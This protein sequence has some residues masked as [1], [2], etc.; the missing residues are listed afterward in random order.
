MNMMRLNSSSVWLV[1]QQNRGFTYCK[2]E[3]AGNLAQH[4]H[5]PSSSRASFSSSLLGFACLL[6]RPA[7]AHEDPITARQSPAPPSFHQPKCV[8][9]ST[10][11]LYDHPVCLDDAAHAALRSLCFRP[12][13]SSLADIQPP[14]HPTATQPQPN[15]SRQQ[16]Q[17]PKPPSGPSSPRKAKSRAPQNYKSPSEKHAEHKTLI[18]STRLCRAKHG[19]IFWQC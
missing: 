17:P 4:H 13:P 10:F 9:P 3:M 7:H 18:G 12:L 2:V 5:P 14:F 1:I 15:F 6:T 16:H 11:A 19:Y 8:V